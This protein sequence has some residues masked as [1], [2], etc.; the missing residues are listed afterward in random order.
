MTIQ[1]SPRFLG[2][3][4]FLASGAAVA[5]GF[6]LGFS[7]PWAVGARRPKCRRSTPGW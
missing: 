2:R 6:S 5:G 3:R 4:G 1:T 7:F